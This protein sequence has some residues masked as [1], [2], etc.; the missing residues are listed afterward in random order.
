MNFMES[1]I[2][3]YDSYRFSDG[4]HHYQ[5]FLKKNASDYHYDTILYISHH[6]TEKRIHICQEIE[7]WTS[8]KTIYYHETYTNTQNI[9]ECLHSFLE[10]YKID[11]QQIYDED[12]IKEPVD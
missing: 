5:W 6:E 8:A 3:K 1:G 10:M 11:P 2:K 7:S 12:P 4:C 9:E